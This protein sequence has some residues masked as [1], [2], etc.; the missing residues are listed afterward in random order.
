M[1]RITERKSDPR[2]APGGDPSLAIAR[3]LSLHGDRIHALARRLCRTTADADDLVQDVFLQAFR[4]WSTFRGDA[5]PGTWLYTIAMR[6]GR[7]RWRQASRARSL[8]STGHLMPWSESTVMS[9]VSRD[10]G[11]G[12]AERAEAIDAIQRAVT[13]LPEH[14]R[15][16]IV[17]K[18]VLERPVDEIA[19]MLGLAVNTVK[20]RLHRGRLFLRRTAAEQS[21]AV[22][23]PAPIYEKQVCL[24]LLKTKLAAMDE[25]RRFAIP[26]AELCARCRSVFRELDLVHDAC[27]EMSRGALPVGLRRSIERAIAARESTT[28]SP[29]RRGRRP[30]T[31]S[32][33]R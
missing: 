32:R 13:L 9:V 4:R 27:A 7:R 17:L 2:L 11:S 23:A 20:T 5:D 14:L 30:V 15:V 12:R 21:R 22:T 28:P 3:L 10:D 18:E 31:P 8:P 24:D 33:P 16:P 25:G 26:Q 19:T 6:M 29:K 1:T